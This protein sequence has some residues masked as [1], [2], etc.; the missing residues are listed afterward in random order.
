MAQFKNL[1]WEKNNSVG[2]LKI[3]RPEALNAL[4]S[5]TLS[6]LDVCFDQLAEDKDLRCVILT[7]DGEKSFVAGADIKFVSTLDAESARKFA[8][9][10][11]RIFSKIESLPFA[12]IAAVNGFALGGGLELALS[13]DFIICHEKAKFALPEVSLGLLPGFGGTVRLSRVVGLNKARELT[14]SGEMIAAAE[15]LRINLVSAVTPVD[16]LMAAAIKSAEAISRQGPV[17]VKLAKKSILKAFDLP[18][19]E[20]M[21]S[22][23]D[24]FSELFNSSDVKEG[25]SAFIE[26]RKPQFKGL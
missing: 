12:V 24:L 21:N 23:A 18:V 13:C 5:E 14:L 19:H 7:G 17:A 4:N 11:Q 2:T 15:A 3:S 10:G 9:D 1:K 6:E 26:K 22:E 8:K 16:Q 25:T 20:A